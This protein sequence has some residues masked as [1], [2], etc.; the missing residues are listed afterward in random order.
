MNE[1]NALAKNAAQA[2][3]A[4]HQAQEQ[5]D[6]A[7]EQLKPVA[8]LQVELTKKVYSEMGV[9]LE[10]YALRGYRYYDWI[11][12]EIG[13]HY[14]GDSDIPAITCQLWER[15][16]CGDPDTYETSF[17]LSRHIINGEP[18]KFEQE[19]REK[20]Q[21]KAAE[22]AQRRERTKAAEIA[23]LQQQLEELQK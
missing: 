20:L 22:E 15:G 11:E 6:A 7:L 8:K 4:F 2:A 1:L 13:G 3:K 10:G 9:P 12:F 17:T 18:E 21:K 19:L 23:R 16:R 5:L 14:E